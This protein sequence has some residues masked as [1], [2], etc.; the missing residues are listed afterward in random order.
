MKPESPDSVI[1]TALRVI[2][3][4]LNA[5][6]ARAKSAEAER[7]ELKRKLSQ[8][9]AERRALV[10]VPFMRRSEAVETI[11]AAQAKASSIPVNTSVPPDWQRVRIDAAIAA[12]QGMLADPELEK[13]CY[14][15]AEL[16]VAHSASLVDELKKEVK[17]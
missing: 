3:D 7:D 9:E 14:E 6:L 1:I 11:S 5:R 17:L 2:T 16:A 15:I 13:R 4:E 8:G 10:Q 12:M